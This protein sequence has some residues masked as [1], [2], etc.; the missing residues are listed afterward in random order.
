VFSGERPVDDCFD[1]TTDPDQI[2]R[3]FDLPNRIAY[4][5]MAAMLTEMER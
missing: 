3:K 4:A 5:K 2:A 1:P